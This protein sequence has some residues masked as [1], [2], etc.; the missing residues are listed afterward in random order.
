[1]LPKLIDADEA[2]FPS[3]RLCGYRAT[4]G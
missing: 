3:A 4:Y 2:S 1:V